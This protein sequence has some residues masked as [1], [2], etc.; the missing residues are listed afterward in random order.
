MNRCC[1]YFARRIS[2]RTRL[3]FTKDGRERQIVQ[4]LPMMQSSAMIDPVRLA[5]R[6]FRECDEFQPASAPQWIRLAVMFL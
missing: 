1:K 4:Q 6:S 2:F 5:A 3:G